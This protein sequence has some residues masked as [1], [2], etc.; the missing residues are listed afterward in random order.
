M[1]KLLIAT[2]ILLSYQLN[3]NT[4]VICSLPLVVNAES[5]NPYVEIWK[6]V[7]MVEST[8]NAK[9]Y[10]RREKATGIAQIRPIKL[11]D[12]NQRTHSHYTLVDCY[13][14]EVSKKIFMYYAQKFNPNEYSKIAIDWNKCRNNTY[15]LKVKKYIKTT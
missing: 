3:C 13:K 6:A 10:N 7:C 15:W 4:M 14:V 2:V 9:A 5:I 11:K 8:N 1:K 12:Y